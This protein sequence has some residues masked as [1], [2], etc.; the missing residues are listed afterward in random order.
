MQLSAVLR[1]LPLAGSVALL[2]GIGLYWALSDATRSEV[3]MP[4]PIAASQQIDQYRSIEPIRPIPLRIDVDQRKVA[5]GER[6]FADTRLSA[7]NS[8]SCASCHDLAKGGVRPIGPEAD[9]PPGSIAVPTVFNA[10]F[11]FAAFW[12]G[13]AAS[14]EDQVDWVIK[15]PVEMNTTWSAIVAKLLADPSYAQTLR[16]VYGTTI[17][18]GEIRDAIATF[19]RSLFTPNSRFDRYLRGET[20][21]LSDAEVAGYELFKSYGCAS[22]HQG[23]NVGGNMFQKFG[24]MG[25]YFARRG[26]VTTADFG[27]F[28]ATGHE[29]D[30]YV[31]KVPS[32]RNVAIRGPYFHDGSARTLEEAVETMAEFQLGRILSNE[33][34]EHLVAFLK[35]L[36]GEYKGKPL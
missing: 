8:L 33:Q 30:R 5:L 7:R 10:G 20:A 21:A 31:F 1:W 9:A 15:N 14:L 27:R 4:P 17:T 2:P 16:Q 34:A 32:L 11:N 3:W 35:T 18:A 6:L 24:I 28:N 19:E 13:R 22:C 26:N 23:T 36:T 12:N 29:E 25:D